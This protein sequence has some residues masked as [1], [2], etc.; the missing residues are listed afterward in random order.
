[1]AVMLCL[2]SRGCV[3]V[4]SPFVVVGALSRVLFASLLRAASVESQEPEGERDSAEDQTLF[5]E[6]PHRAFSYLSVGYTS[7]TIGLRPATCIRM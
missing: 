2:I 6:V 1:M 3:I 7:L 5:K 4:A